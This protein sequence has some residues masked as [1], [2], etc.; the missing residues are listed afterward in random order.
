MF[1][2]GEDLAER[3][4]VRWREATAVLGGLDRHHD[5][6][7][8]HDALERVRDLV[9]ERVRD[10][11]EHA[12]DRDQVVG[13]G[14]AGL[15]RGHDLLQ[16]GAAPTAVRDVQE[17]SVPE[18]SALSA[19]AITHAGDVRERVLH[20]LLGHHGECIAVELERPIRLTGHLA[21]LLELA[22][23]HHGERQGA[24][25]LDHGR[26][27]HIVLGQTREAKRLGQ[28]QE[29]ERREKQSMRRV[30][31]LQV[32]GVLDLV[33]VG[34]RVAHLVLAPGVALD[35]GHDVVREAAG[36]DPGALLR[37]EI[38]QPG[39]DCPDTF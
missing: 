29:L 5:L 25:A 10:L 37:H 7:L 28:G 26:G 38:L 6:V 23:L 21:A 11:G 1:D 13:P 24:Q 31:R 32:H 17:V 22:L 39:R 9:L 19:D 33:R 8:H 16:H 27:R 2:A 34:S 3:D 12:R 35:Q 30:P 36:D 14:H 18:L 20:V 15:P 4:E